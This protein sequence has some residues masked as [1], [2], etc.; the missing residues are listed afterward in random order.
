MTPYARGFNDF[1]NEHPYN[2]P[3]SDE[4]SFKEYEQG[5]NEARDLFVAD[6][7]DVFEHPDY[8]NVIV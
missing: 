5:Y 1:H 6:I 4:K 3:F 8:R 2:N 7:E